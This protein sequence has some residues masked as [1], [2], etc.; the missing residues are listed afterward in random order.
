[1]FA[2]MSC[3]LNISPQEPTNLKSAEQCYSLLFH[4]SL[5]LLQ[6]MSTVVSFVSIFIS[7]SQYNFPQGETVCVCVCVCVSQ[8]KGA[9]REVLQTSKK[10]GLFLLTAEH[11]CG[12]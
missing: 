1:M 2:E 6:C 12:M 11:V 4:C 3:F 7:L 5:I 10:K 8:M 9:L